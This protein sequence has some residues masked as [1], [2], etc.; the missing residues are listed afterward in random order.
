MGDAVANATDQL[1]IELA[2]QGTKLVAVLGSGLFVL[3]TAFIGLAIAYVNNANRTLDL[4]SQQVTLSRENNEIK[5]AA[6]ATGSQPNSS[7]KAGSVAST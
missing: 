2:N 6:S 1:I 5:K 3:V 4:R 7:P